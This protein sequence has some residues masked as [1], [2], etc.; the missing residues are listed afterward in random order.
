MRRWQRRHSEERRLV[1]AISTLVR[2]HP[3]D[4]RSVVPAVCPPILK[5]NQVRM[6]SFSVGEA[7][8]L[9]SVMHEIGVDRLL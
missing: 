5:P 9:L 6:T 1:V 8:E 3:G 4:I 2:A 7:K